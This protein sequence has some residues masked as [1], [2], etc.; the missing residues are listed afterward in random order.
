MN[1]YLSKAKTV[2]VEYPKIFSLILVGIILCALSGIMV[3]HGMWQ[4]DLF[5]GPLIWQPST[6]GLQF[7]QDL[8]GNGI[9]SYASVP[10]TDF[11][12]HTTVGG[13]MDTM[14]A[15]ITIGWVM[16]MVGVGL[17]GMGFWMFLSQQ[18]QSMKTKLANQEKIMFK[19]THV[20]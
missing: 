5:A 6:H 13:I 17:I 9:F 1:K 12:L 10:A 14:M 15:L 16:G 11:F 4:I 8:V 20:D 3:I 7:Y 2:A 18:V 19:R